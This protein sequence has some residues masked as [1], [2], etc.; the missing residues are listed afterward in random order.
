MLLQVSSKQAKMKIAAVSADHP[1]PA[2]V[3]LAVAWSPGRLS[4]ECETVGDIPEHSL[5]LP[6]S[7]PSQH[8]GAFAVVTKESPG[9]LPTA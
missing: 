1:L 2:L 3:K 7:T 4:L 8:N 5:W 9:Y 6:H